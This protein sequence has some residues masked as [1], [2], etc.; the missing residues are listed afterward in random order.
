MV[1]VDPS[2]IGMEPSAKIYSMTVGFFSRP[3][4]LGIVAEAFRPITK[5]STMLNR[6]LIPSEIADINIDA[7]ASRLSVPLEY[8]MGKEGVIFPNLGGWLDPESDKPVR[9]SLYIF[10]HFLS[11]R[12]SEAK[13]NKKIMHLSGLVYN[14]LSALN[15]KALM[16]MAFVEFGFLFGQVLDDRQFAETKSEMGITYIEDKN[17]TEREIY[18]RFDFDIEG[19]YAICRVRNFIERGIVSNVDNKAEEIKCWNQQITADCAMEFENPMEMPPFDKVYEKAL[20]ST[21]EYMKLSC[22]K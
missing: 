16:S 21:N 5:V 19:N 12:I 3:D 22:V 13:A 20:V 7:I 11:L 6:P 1:Q 2:E 8:L 14:I 15:Q 18:S 9:A 17:V 4:S 10:P